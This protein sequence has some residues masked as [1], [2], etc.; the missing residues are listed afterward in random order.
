MRWTPTL[1][2]PLLMV[3]MVGF[4]AY[5]MLAA[6]A[7]GS[8]MPICFCATPTISWP[9]MGSLGTRRT[10]NVRVHSIAYA[11]LVA[12]ARALFP[13]SRPEGRFS[14]VSPPS[15]ADLHWF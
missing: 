10:T 7:P 2:I 8:T 12:G 11:F 4:Y 14:R 13:D 3:E 1:V 6:R 15:S 5:R 9:E